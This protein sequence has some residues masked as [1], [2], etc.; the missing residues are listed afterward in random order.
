MEQNEILDENELIAQR[1]VKLCE[2]RER[3][4]AFPNDFRRDVVAGELHA[5]YKDADNETL[6]KEKIHVNVAG[7]IMLCRIMGKASFIQLQDMS[8]RI[9]CYL[10]KN[11]LGEQ[12][13]NEFKKWRSYSNSW[14]NKNSIYIGYKF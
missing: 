2:L 7:R 9:Q 5:R 10:R 8:G 1:K 6:E 4:I 11:E 12:V 13:Y 3:G 14:C